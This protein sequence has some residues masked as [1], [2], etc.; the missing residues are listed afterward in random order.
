M[1]AKIVKDGGIDVDISTLRGI[2]LEYLKQV[3][4]LI[5]EFNHI[6]F[7]IASSETQEPEYHIFPNSPVEYYF[8]TNDSLRVHYEEWIEYWNEYKKNH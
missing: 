5:F 6:I 2:K 8:D 3:E 4:N 1:S 7:N